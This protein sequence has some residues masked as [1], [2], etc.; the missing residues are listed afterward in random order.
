M[1]TSSP[2]AISC[3]L[4]SVQTISMSHFLC[5]REWPLKLNTGKR[6]NSIFRQYS[7]ILQEYCTLLYFWLHHEAC[8]ILVPQ[9]GTEPMLP[10]VGAQTLSHWATKKVQQ[11]VLQ[12]YFQL[13]KSRFIRIPSKSLTH[14]EQIWS[15]PQSLTFLASVIYIRY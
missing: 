14:K 9:A 7:L 2:L 4:S 6:K 8:R 10:S 5:N 3:S 13:R 1:Y 11:H 12:V 15:S